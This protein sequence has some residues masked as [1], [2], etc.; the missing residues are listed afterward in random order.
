MQ[1]AFFL[2][3]KRRLGE[4]GV[5][6]AIADDQRCGTHHAASSIVARQLEAGACNSNESSKPRCQHHELE[7]ARFASVA[8]FRSVFDK[9]SSHIV[10]HPRLA[11]YAT[12]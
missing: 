4:K 9:V 6:D 12:L 11:H 3:L 8:E 2:R 10:G 1:R 7:F 5:V